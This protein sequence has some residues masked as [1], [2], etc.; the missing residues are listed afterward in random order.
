MT[1]V[2][3]CGITRVEDARAALA[4]GATALGFV[5]W[6]ASP[7]AVTPEQAG[8]I[9]AALPYGTNAVGVFVNQTTDEI[10]RAVRVAGLT[11]VQLHGDETPALLPSIHRPVLRAINVTA[12]DAAIAA[13]PEPVLLLV[14]AHDPVRRGGTGRVADWTAAAALA[15]K[16]RIVLAGGLRA[17]NVQE[18][19]RVVR[20]FGLDVSSGVE[21]APGVKSVAKL[22]DFFEKVRTA[23]GR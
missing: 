21:D 6:P 13:W 11:A 14:D 19:I 16:R 12:D 22:N 23:D 9:V 17:D 10:D 3:V 15:A 1:F 7:R 2:K 20:P 5:F 8:A 18:A 4:A